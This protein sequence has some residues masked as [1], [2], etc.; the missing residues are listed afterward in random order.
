MSNVPKI[1]S[2]T[3]I[4]TT[5]LQ[6]CKNGIIRIRKQIKKRK[7]KSLVTEIQKINKQN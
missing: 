7:N 5:S 6:V 3:P 4:N 2:V 1:F